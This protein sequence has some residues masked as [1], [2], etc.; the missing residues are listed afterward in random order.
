MTNPDVAEHFA[1]LKDSDWRVRWN[2]V[3]ALLRLGDVSAVPALIEALKDSD[4]RRRAIDALGKIGSVS[5]VPALIEVLKDNH[6]SIQRNATHALGKIGTPAVPA[7]IEAL[8]DSDPYVR[9][10]AAEALG[11]I[12]DATTLP[13]KVLAEQRL[14]PQYRV[15]TL[16]A[17]R[18]VRYNDHRHILRYRIPDV[19]AYCQ[20]QLE[21]ED[22]AV[23]EGAEAV[24]AWLHDSSHLLRASQRDT[25]TE[26]QELLRA[27]Q[28]GTTATQPETLLRAADE[29][30]I[31]VEP[32]EPK[33]TFWQRL[34]KPQSRAV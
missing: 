25:T 13:R 4:V 26:S 21:D 19:K 32:A 7:L 23:R 28:S 30:P 3:D 31:E 17:L 2:A 8:K 20:Q 16:S 12:G 6:W 14:T 22:P 33:P 1:R 10:Y 27:E 11:E 15:E 24:L 34:R 18:R 5:A 9:G 29:T